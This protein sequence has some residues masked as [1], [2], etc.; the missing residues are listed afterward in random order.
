MYISGGRWDGIPGTDRL[1]AEAL[2]AKGK[3]LW[4]DQ[5]ASIMRHRDVLR[6]SAMSLRGRTETA[7]GNI[8]RLR[9][10]AL[11]GFS[12]AVIRRTTEALA[13]WTMH[14]AAKELGEITGVVNA[15]PL[16]EFPSRITAPRLLHV[17]DDWLSASSLLGLKRGHVARLL[18]SNLRMA[19][20]VTA[21]TPALASKLAAISGRPVD[22][23]PNGCRAPLALVPG[24]AVAPYAVLAGQLNERLDP[25]ILEELAR[26]GLPVVVMGPRT[27]RDP[28]MS[29]TLDRFLAQPNVRWLGHVAP[30][31]VARVLADAA[32]GLT[33]YAVSEF[34]TASF[35]LK[36]LEYLAAGLPV[37]ATD[38]PA[39]RW[40]GNPYVAVAGNAGE[41]VAMTRAALRNPPTHARRLDIQ[42][43]SHAHTWEVRAEHLLALLGGQQT[44]EPGQTRAPRPV[45]SN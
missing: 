9:P 21:V 35:P 29:R 20:R 10:P 42:A 12:R 6:H 24:P 30:A 34:N 32:A 15:S 11:P 45:G 41:Y 27:E 23:L 39:A 1:L 28:G 25:N 44:P 36:T 22:V 13:Q 40:L 8:F 4:V 37:V 18:T 3:V 16:V 7:H 2:A 38:L 17:T 33:P 5:P 14:A 26:C 31:E 43:T 19:D